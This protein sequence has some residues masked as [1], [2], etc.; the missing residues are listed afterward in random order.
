MRWRRRSS[1]SPATSRRRSSPVRSPSQGAQALRYNGYKIPLMRNLVKRAIV[2][3]RHLTWSLTNAHRGAD[4]RPSDVS[5][6]RSAGKQ[7]CSCGPTVRRCERSSLGVSMDFVKW[8]LNP[9][10]QSILT[11]VSW[12][13]F[14]ASLFAGA[15]V[16]RGSRQLHAAVGASQATRDRDRQAGSGLLPTCPTRIERH[17]LMARAFHWVMAAAMFVLLFTA[18][19][20]VVGVQVRLGHVALDRWS[21]ADGIDCLPHHPR[22]GLARLLVDLGWSEGHPRIEGRNPA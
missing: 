11:H 9:W 10:G 3:G 21:R 2:A 15:D 17:S 6:A 4:V 18:F 13:L 16:S 7:C 22:V 14:W 1:A 19:L 5:P 12:T 20:P 8:G